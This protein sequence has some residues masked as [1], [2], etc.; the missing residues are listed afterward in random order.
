MRMINEIFVD[1]GNASERQHLKRTRNEF[2]LERDHATNHREIAGKAPRKRMKVGEEHADRGVARI[3][4][5]MHKRRAGKHCGEGG[6]EPPCMQ[7]LVEGQVSALAFA[8]NG[9]REIVGGQSLR[10]CL[11]QV[12]HALRPHA[13][14]DQSFAEIRHAFV[15][16]NTADL[17]M[18][19]EHLFEQRRA[20]AGHSHHERGGL[21]VNP[22]RAH[23]RA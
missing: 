10:V 7:C 6:Q 12:A 21:R 2:A 11:L 5:N 1:D 17:R 20:A 13:Q 4:L 9:A 14:R 19:I 8:R 16:A 18:S 22:R 23:P 3:A 15:F